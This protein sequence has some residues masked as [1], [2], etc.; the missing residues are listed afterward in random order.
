MAHHPRLEK[1]RDLRNR[2]DDP[3]DA[4]AKISSLKST[5]NS[6]KITK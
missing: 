5:F 4:A 6:L 2:N 1:V 3:H